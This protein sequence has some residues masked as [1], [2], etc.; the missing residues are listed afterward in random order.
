MFTSNF[1]STNQMNTPVASPQ[2]TMRITRVLLV[3]T[4]TYGQQWGRPY[5]TQLNGGIL[6]SLRERM[7]G[8]PDINASVFSGMGASFLTPQAAPERHIDIVSGWNERR[9]RMMLEVEVQSRN[10]AYYEIL[11]GYTDHTGISM[12]GSIDP[13]MRFY[14]NSV[15]KMRKSFIATPLGNEQRLAVAG[16]GHVLVNSNWDGVESPNQLSLMRPMD[17]YS[18]MG[19]LELPDLSSMNVRDTRNMLMDSPKLSRRSNNASS[20]YAASIVAGYRNA[21]TMQE[22]GQSEQEVLHTAVT[23]TVEESATG[24]QV[25]SALAA[26]QHVPHTNSF[27]WRHLERLDP[28][29]NRDEITRVVIR[30]QTQQSY[31]GEHYAGQ[32]ADWGEASIEAQIATMMSQTVPS[33]MMEMGLTML[34]FAATNRIPGIQRHEVII[35]GSESF[36]GG[37]HSQFLQMMKVRLEVDLLEEISQSNLYDY[38]IEMSVDV[39]G[40]THISISIQGQPTVVYCTPSFCDA[41]LSPVVTAS[42][43]R[44]VELAN[45]F[46]VLF[47]ETLKPSYGSMQVSSFNS[48]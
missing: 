44:A 14:V 19:R 26:F 34:T 41:L 24:D 33:L 39:V 16:A 38:E 48:L 28:N 27:Q 37:D 12:S 20:N 23:Y 42:D 22:L 8:A 1:P 9:I 7:D 5:Q 46:Q 43:G 6:T 11:L 4:G 29:V 36:A 32:T 31:M 40:E 2:V 30:G 47:S 17:V 13:N 21:S 45:D 15:M 35:T 10:G 25:L 3:E 18:T